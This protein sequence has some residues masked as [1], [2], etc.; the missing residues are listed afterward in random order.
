MS[1][2]I[3][4]LRGGFSD[5]NKIV[6][7]NIEIQTTEF[8]E[9]TRNKLANLVK[10]WY[11]IISNAGYSEW[12][13]ENILANVYCEFISDQ[14]KDEVKYSNNDFF[15]EYICEPILNNSYDDVLTIIEYIVKEFMYVK[16][17]YFERHRY[18]WGSY[19]NPFQEYEKELNQLFQEEFVG[20]RIIEGQIT[21]ISD[22]IEVSE[23]KKGLN[24]QFDG[25]KSHIKKSLIFLSNREN[26][27]YKNSIK[28][29]IS[30]VESICKIITN[31]KK[32][33]LGN[34][35]DKLKG[36]GNIIHPS[37]LEAFSKLY[38]YTS[39]EG[40]IRHA[41]GLFESNVSFCQAKYMLVSC[42]AFVNYLLE[43]YSK[44]DNSK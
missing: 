3:I 19:E 20:Y 36:N 28:E 7:V 8:D 18:D 6:P 37:L 12:F 1:E 41:E 16:N 31:N 24:I 25:C 30:A 33:T 42:C 35:L 27:D 4:Q 29:S 26:P 13:C 5:R 10:N 22:D 32:A 21:S 23:I 44:N 11:L 38:G 17:L 39:N 40:G 2:K 14:L 9:R 43:E 15:N 34:A